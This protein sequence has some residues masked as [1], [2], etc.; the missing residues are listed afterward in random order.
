MAGQIRLW[1]GTDLM[2][3]L[4]WPALR[5]DKGK[6]LPFSMVDIRVERL[7][8]AGAAVKAGW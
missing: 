5:G 6:G 7:H 2:T 1:R 8:H 3:T 4:I